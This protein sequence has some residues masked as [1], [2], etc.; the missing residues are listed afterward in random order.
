MTTIL[1]GE[2]PQGKPQALSADP[3]G[4]VGVR[5]GAYGIS[6]NR[7]MPAAQLSHSGA[8][9]AGVNTNARTWTEADGVKSVEIYPTAALATVD[10]YCLVVMDAPNGTIEKSFLDAVSAA[11]AV[12][13]EFLYFKVPINEKTALP[14]AAGAL[15]RVGVKPTIICH[16]ALEA[17]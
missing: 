6:H 1:H 2:N 7:D 12:D 17:V 16:I 15:R 13:E 8:D 11:N 5:T 9:V 3:D 14:A 10:D 4:S